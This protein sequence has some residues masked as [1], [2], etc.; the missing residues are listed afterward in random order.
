MNNFLIFTLLL[1]LS[2]NSRLSADDQKTTY[3]QSELSHKK[4]VLALTLINR[5]GDVFN[6]TLSTLNQDD[7]KKISHLYFTKEEALSTLKSAL[8]KTKRTL[9]NSNLRFTTHGKNNETVILNKKNNTFY[10]LADIPIDLLKECISLTKIEKHIELQI[11]LELNQLNLAYSTIESN[12]HIPLSTELLSFM[13]DKINL[14]FN[15][16]IKN[17][18]NVLSIDVNKTDLNKL[19]KPDKHCLIY[20]YQREV[21]KH[22]GK[23]HPPKND[24]LSTQIKNALTNKKFN[25]SVKFISS[26]LYDGDLSINIAFKLN[27]QRLILLPGSHNTPLLTGTHNTISGSSASFINNTTR[28][29]GKNNNL[30]NLKIV[31]NLILHQD[32]KNLTIQNSDI[33]GMLISLE[34][35][36]ASV[37]NSVMRGFISKKNKN[38]FFKNCTFLKPVNDYQPTI[39]AGASKFENCVIF[40]KSLL[41][42]RKNLEKKPEFINCLLYTE[43]I[44]GEYNYN[45]YYNLA[46]S[47]NKVAE[48]KKSSMRQLFFI[49]IE[50]QNYQLVDPYLNN[51]YVGVSQSLHLHL[52]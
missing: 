10:D 11:Y 15:K 12:R 30:V 39:E 37:R 43:N 33:Y 48:F 46:D 3:T 7:Q 36:T 2:P 17:L 35:S 31:K 13:L 38:T 23:N 28:V 34:N 50:H 4:K 27:R 44:L 52:E 22:Y 9:T 18:Y 24:N 29:E 20:I 40:S 14:S 16:K 25:E 19:T 47:H 51:K 5:Q 1:I 6:K 42:L 41:I 49:D 21:T 26:D 32:T 8:R 45:K